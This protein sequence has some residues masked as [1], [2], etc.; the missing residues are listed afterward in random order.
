M[1]RRDADLGGKA[2]MPGKGKNLVPYLK[3]F[4]AFPQSRDHAGYLAAGG[5]GTLG[6]NL[7]QIT[8][9]QSIGK[10]DACGADLDQ[11]FPLPG[12]RSGMSVQ[13]SVSGP[14]AAVLNI[15]FIFALLA[16]LWQPSVS[17]IT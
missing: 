5:K 13:T 12:Q 6:L 14:P 7:V 10:V 8:N 4:D 9:N 15:D 1:R 11:E 3:A 2:A 17:K 16:A